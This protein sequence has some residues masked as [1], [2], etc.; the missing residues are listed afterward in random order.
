MII[1]G[2]SSVVTV[3]N[4]KVSKLFMVFPAAVANDMESICIKWLNVCE[5]SVVVV[6]LTLPAL[7][8]ICSFTVGVIGGIPSPKVIRAYISGKRAIDKSSG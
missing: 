6:I 3:P 1:Y 4:S 8:M 5:S 7:A 2:S